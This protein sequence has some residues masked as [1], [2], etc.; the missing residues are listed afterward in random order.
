ML[1]SVISSFATGI[2]AVTRTVASTYDANGILVPGSSAV[3]NI[4]ASIQPMSGMS[5]QA[6]PEGHHATNLRKMY[7][8]EALFTRTPTNDPD[9]V[10][11]NGEEWEVL[12]VE[13]WEAFG[14]GNGAD[15]YKAI[16]A[17]QVTP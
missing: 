12:S 11:F 3:V 5:L 13:S 2:Y 6:L 4:S 10:L 1:K 8:Q 15:H 14:S 9:K 17:R 16:I 7:A